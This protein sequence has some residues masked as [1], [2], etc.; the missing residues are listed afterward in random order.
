MEEKTMNHDDSEGD[1]TSVL[2]KMTLIY[3]KH[4]VQI[5]IAIHG[6]RILIDIIL[7]LAGLTRGLPLIKS[8][9]LASST[10]K[11]FVDLSNYIAQNDLNKQENIQKIHRAKCGRDPKADLSQ[12]TSSHLHCIYEAI[13]GLTDRCTDLE[14]VV[15]DLHDLLE[16]QRG[17][18]SRSPSN[19]PPNR[20]RPTPSST[21]S[22]RTART[23]LPGRKRVKI[24]KT[25]VSYR[26]K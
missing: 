26:T 14:D 13:L 21:P 8:V 9:A 15:N 7:L 19:S 11:K 3:R 16:L 2:T 25:G 24:S 10:V 1:E 23:P 12:I 4:S 18:G 20:R 5:Q 22:P 17:Q 6:F